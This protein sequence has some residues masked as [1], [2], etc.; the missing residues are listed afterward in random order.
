M[1]FVQRIYLK[2]IIYTKQTIKALERRVGSIIRSTVKVVPRINMKLA[3][4]SR[5]LVSA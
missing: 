5:K 1:K 4:S 2:Y 3:I